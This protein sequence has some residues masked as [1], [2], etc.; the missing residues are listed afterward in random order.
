MITFLN[1]EKLVVAANQ[2]TNPT[3]IDCRSKLLPICSNSMC[4]G[5]LMTGFNPAQEIP[6]H[7]RRC[8]DG[9]ATLL[10]QLLL[11]RP[12]LFSER[13]YTTEDRS[14]LRLNG[15]TAQGIF[16]FSVYLYTNEMEELESTIFLPFNRRHS[17]LTC[18]LSSSRT[19]GIFRLSILTIFSTSRTVNSAAL[20]SRTDGNHHSIRSW[21]RG[22][23]HQAQR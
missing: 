23:S 19:K 7:L 12:H 3:S 8:V 10:G 5:N 15:F 17:R 2:V 20:K 1:P 11:C 9:G 4:R 18:S 6:L 22:R 21:I 13:A 14:N 16:L